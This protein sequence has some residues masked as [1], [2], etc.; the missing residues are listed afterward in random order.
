MLKAIA[1]SSGTRRKIPVFECNGGRKI[2]KDRRN[3]GRKI[4]TTK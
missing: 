1:E 2:N 3:E 4:E